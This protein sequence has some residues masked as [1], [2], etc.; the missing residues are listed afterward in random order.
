M[1]SPLAFAAEDEEVSLTGSPTDQKTP[2]YQSIEIPE[3]FSKLAAEVRGKIENGTADWFDTRYEQVY[4]ENEKRIAQQQENMVS[5]T[6][7][8][9]VP[10]NGTTT[11][12]ENPC[13]PCSN[14][15]PICANPG[16]QYY[17][18]Y[19]VEN[20]VT[21]Y[22]SPVMNCNQRFYRSDGQEPTS[23]DLMVAA[24]NS[25]VI[26]GKLSHAEAA[27][28][29]L[30]NSDFSD[31]DIAAI[32]MLEQLKDI[33]KRDIISMSA[34]QAAEDEK[35][36]AKAE[37][38]EQVNKSYQDA[39]DVVSELSGN[40]P[41]T[42]KLNPPIPSVESPSEITLTLIPKDK[43]Q[44]GK[45]DITLTFKNLVTGESITKPVIEEL[46]YP[47][48]PPEWASIPGSRIVTI[49]YHNAKSGETLRS[50]FSYGLSESVSVLTGN[51][52]TV[53]NSVVGAIAN[54]DIRASSGQSFEVIG[55]I[56]DA[57]F[58]SSRNACMVTVADENISFGR[59]A[60]V[61][62]QDVTA[63]DCNSS[64]GTYARMEHVTAVMDATT[65]EIS[66]LSSGK[67]SNGSIFG[68]S[69]EQYLEFQEASDGRVK[70][71]NGGL[72]PKVI[73]TLGNNDGYVY[74]NYGKIGVDYVYLIGGEPL[75]VKYYTDEEWAEKIKV[76]MGVLE[77][78]KGMKVTGGYVPVNPDGSEISEMEL[79]NIA[80]KTG[81]DYNS[82][83][84]E[85]GANG[86]CVVKSG[87]SIVSRTEFNSSDI[88][89]G[90]SQILGTNERRLAYG[91]SGGNLTLMDAMGQ[92]ATGMANAVIPKI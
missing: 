23:R 20:N 65:G 38:T 67:N 34:Y 57:Y 42:I 64:V 77:L 49:T 25:D 72:S 69:Q 90:V 8:I 52:K 24:V 53:D 92:T 84:F 91:K 35:N 45:Y 46:A 32:M 68:N 39:R 81:L 18:N 76:S 75:P 4:A 61:A 89:K 15:S 74:G 10:I 19:R 47:I 59:E 48:E 30:M 7:N 36:A 55:K 41:C 60:T 83:T 43:K 70:K 17:P 14:P 58:D 1:L 2:E 3:N 82:L 13:A 87:D 9:E 28:L 16:G 63:K 44:K 26:A 73:Q 5:T 71:V 56:K 50:T 88:N 66:L 40:A 85:T 37:R 80:R 22:G 12:Y 51:G 6:P 29:V 79:A 33:Q 86:E 62:V 27:G 31:N 54:L 11:I 78:P 21:Y